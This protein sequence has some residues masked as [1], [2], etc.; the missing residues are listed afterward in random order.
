M[1]WVRYFRI[2]FASCVTGQ[3]A[4]VGI[5]LGCVRIYFASSVTGDA[6]A[7][8]GSRVVPETFPRLC[9]CLW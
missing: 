8:R 2:F 5:G 6:D 9:C 1:L 3:C 4:A 7:L